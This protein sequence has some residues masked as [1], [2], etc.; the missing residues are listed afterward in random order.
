[1]KRLL[2]QKSSSSSS[3]RMEL[4]LFKRWQCLVVVATD[5]ADVLPVASADS[6]L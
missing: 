6:G 2:K 3:S 5:W 1:M 4:R